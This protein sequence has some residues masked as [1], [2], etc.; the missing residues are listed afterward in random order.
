MSS[1]AVE[2]P[3]KRISATSW[4]QTPKDVQAV[5]TALAAEVVRLRE[6]AKRNSR[7]SSQPPSQ[8]S[9]EA[10]AVQAQARQE[11][12]SGQQGH[13]GKARALLPVEQVDAV[14]KC[15]PSICGECGCLLL[16]ED[17]Q[18]Q[19]HQVTELPTVKAQVIEYQL[20]RLTCPCCQTVNVEPLPAGIGTSQFGAQ[21]VSTLVL[22]MGRYRLSKRQVVD[23]LE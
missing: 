19:R 13:V 5:V 10:K 2:P 12:R 17:R 15:K 1:Q 7:N 16:G 14:V 21:L 3:D 11:R 23:W 9:A 6:Q 4:A 18:P 8:D 20:H 22:L